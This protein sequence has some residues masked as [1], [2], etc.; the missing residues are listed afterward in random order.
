MD[1]CQAHHDPKV[2]G[3]SPAPAT[4]EATAEAPSIDLGAF[5]CI[6]LRLVSPDSLGGV[7]ASIT[8]TGVLAE[9]Y[10]EP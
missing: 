9:W 5:L 7:R 2:A 1:G 6:V 3:S 10:S 8:T 4:I